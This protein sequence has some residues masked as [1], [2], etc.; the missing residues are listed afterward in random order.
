MYANEKCFKLSR[1]SWVQGDKIN[2][3]IALCFYNLHGSFLSVDSDTEFTYFLPWYVLLNLRNNCNF[4]INQRYFS[5]FLFNSPKNSKVTVRLLIRVNSIQFFVG[6]LAPFGSRFS[7]VNSWYFVNIK[8]LDFII[9]SIIARHFK[10]V[11]VSNAAA[12]DSAWNW[13]SI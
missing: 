13:R 5:V 12:G 10:N 3:I 4:N 6:N 7:S 11:K 8:F 2:E 9:I 1:K